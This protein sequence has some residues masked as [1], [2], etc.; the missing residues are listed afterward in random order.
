[1]TTDEQ[2]D[3]LSD[4]VWQAVNILDNKG[5]VPTRIALASEHLRV[6]LRMAGLPER[7]PDLPVPFDDRYEGGR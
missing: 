2:L 4:A 3:L 5:Y 1:M 6:G 7:D